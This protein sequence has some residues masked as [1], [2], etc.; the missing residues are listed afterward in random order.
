LTDR[1]PTMYTVKPQMHTTQGVLAYSSPL[2]LPVLLPWCR[3]S[4]QKSGLSKNTDTRNVGEQKIV[5]ERK[6]AR[7]KYGN[8]VFRPSSTPKSMRTISVTNHPRNQDGGHPA[9][10]NAT[11]FRSRRAG[12]GG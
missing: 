4:F 6:A 3:R 10:V 8:L 1:A 12:G 5:A 2:H 9:A 7:E 11:I